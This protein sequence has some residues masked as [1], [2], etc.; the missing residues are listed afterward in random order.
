MKKRFLSLFLV[1]CMVSSLIIAMPVS[2]SAA[3]SGTCGKNLTWTLD[4]NGKLTISG[5]G[6]MDAGYI[7]VGKGLNIRSVVIQNGVTSISNSAFYGNKN[8]TSVKMADSVTSIGASAFGSCENLSSLTLSSNITFIG[9][10]AFQY[11][12]GITSFAIPSKVTVIEKGTF[13][14][15]ENLKTIV[16]PNGVTK[17]GSSA[18]DC[19][20]SLQSITLPNTVREIGAWAF[21]Q[22]KNI[23]SIK[24]PYGVTTIE[25]AT[26]EACTKL[27][28]I[29]IPNTVTTIKHWAINNCYSLKSIT[30]PISVTTLENKIFSYCPNLKDIYYEG[31][32]ND[33]GYIKIDNSNYRTFDF[34]GINIHYE[35]KNIVSDLAQIVY[36]G[37][38]YNL[39]SQ[40]IS[41]DKDSNV[42]V[43]VWVYY[44]NININ[45]EIY[46]CQNAEKFV[47]I[48]NGV[49]KTFV[50]A[51]VFDA[52]KDI[53]IVI[54]N[55]R[56]GEARSERTGLKIVGD[57][58]SGEFMPEGEIEG[59]NYKL[60]DGVSF[61]VPEGIPIFEGTEIK[62]DYDFI[63]I[64]FEYDHEDS[65]KINV[66]LGFD[67]VHTDGEKNKYFKNFDF[68]EYKKSIKKAA[69]K[70]NRTL[71][72]LRH[73]FKLS[74]NC[75]M[76]LFGGK[77]IG[78]GKGKSSTDVDCAGYAEFKMI[79]GR[80]QFIEGQL[81]LNVEASYK[82]QGQLF[83]WT[84]PVYYEIGV[85]IGAGLE[86]DMINI[87]P[88]QF[89]PEF[90][91]YLTAKL[92]GE[93]GGGIGVAKFATV[94]ASGEGSLNMKTALH[95]EYFKAWGEGEANFNVKIFGKEVAKKTFAKG[96]FL[97]YETGNANGL[98]KDN[99]IIVFE[100]E[101]NDIGGGGFGG[102]GGG[103]ILSATAASL[104]S[105]FNSISI[106]DTYENESRAYASSSTEW[107]GDMP[108]VSLFDAEYTSKNLRLLA[109]NVYTESAPIMCSIDGQ[110]I[111][112]M[113]WDN[114]ER[115]AANRT[116]LV[117]SVYDDSEGVWSAPLPVC[118]DGTADFYPNFNDGYLV[119]QN[120]KS[121]L[122]DSMSL[123][124]IA[125]LG[126]I[127][128]S[129]WNGNGFD[130]PVVLTNNDMLDTQ[131]VVCAFES[132]VS[133]IWTTNSE[134]DILGLSGDNSIV[135]S[136][137][138]GSAWSEPEVIKQGLN[139][140]TNLA[141]GY[142]D[143][144][145]NIAYIQDEDGDL[146]TIDD[147]DISIISDSGEYKLTD[148]DVLDS[149][150]QVKGDKIYYYSNGNIEYR[151]LGSE[152]INTFFAD[153]KA[154]LTDNFSVSE[155]S[156]GG[157]VILWAK[158]IDGATEIFS[159]I[160]NDGK[161]SDEIQI[162][163]TGNQSKYPTAVL[164][165]DGS[166]YIA[167]NNG[168]LTDGE[169][170]QT[171]LY[172][173]DLT[174]S[175]DLSVT[176]AYIDEDTMTVF[177][178]V[179]NS[180]ELNIDSYTVSLIDN[181][182]VNSQ[183]MVTEELK[184]GESA[185]VEIEYIKP[186][187]LTKHT[188]TL[189]VETENDEYNTENNSAELTVGNCDIKITDI[190]NHEILPTSVAVATISNSG[191]SD[192]G[193]VTVKLRKDKA[194]G[195]VV[196]TQTI[197]NISAGTSSE[198]SFNY[199][200]IENDNIQWYIT[201]EAENDEI[202]LGNNDAY[203]INNCLS[204]LP[205]YSQAILRYDIVDEKL[206]VNGYAENNTAVDLSGVS[207]LAVY[208]SKDTLKALTH[209]DAYVYKYDSSSVDLTID[210][211]TYEKGDYIKLFLWTDLK[212]IIPVC[213]ATDSVVIK[214]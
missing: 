96:D 153:A 111:M 106:S 87:D 40:P 80:Y 155:S 191:Y 90:E 123:D 46:L 135:K 179:K 1:I 160:L 37:V 172:V 32:K 158:S 15:C 48:E 211:Y 66:V 204:D 55:I 203:F 134:N 121:L 133:V 39:L 206:I 109:E 140:I 118:D 7:W 212:C 24:I 162:S 84:V 93:I 98:L 63:P 201:A 58:A 104:Y 14:F 190:Q 85:G 16:I 180:G 207:V 18:F 19:C 59:V 137:L 176:D 143:T 185:E 213:E 49:S 125:K 53:Y 202:S 88:E 43:T 12:K 79:D 92:A 214:E 52:D 61:T 31:S 175:Y 91:A 147:R 56:T 17:I 100:D 167:Y 161:W 188:I 199:N 89:V 189:S 152:E 82:Y 103:G 198:V 29:E 126:E 168:I 157:A 23:T 6:E 9:Q 210:D 164:E 13:E 57:V 144:G 50:P 68:A 116:M 129:K 34:Y 117:Y 4:D 145:L 127:C 124:D 113:L 114:S 77:V 45:Q 186:L 35:N 193:A 173:I 25:Q 165:D 2:V 174:P 38:S 194:D 142:A 205:D 47:E 27:S 154:G 81:C 86:G 102:G 192:T 107:Y 42:E 26:F 197:S 94:G 170:T 101:N 30:I 169:I 146:Q 163:E 41:I 97:I 105:T 119:W 149:N 120:E 22:C 128:V 78:G 51:K 83:I 112:V 183:I 171:D 65:N 181:D 150:P 74:N 21:S 187:D 76:N 182:D 141:A 99:D 67:I 5:T 70:Q 148:N 139:T 44:K 11:C 54:R 8:L 72:Q 178:T 136:S 62:W 208:N 156:N 132:E 159:T 33:W 75:K 200:I 195:E 95:K 69:S 20:R 10:E 110:K 60:I 177:A 131:P 28:S 36:N 122:D 115:D 209:S 184:A 108:P 166:I 130:T 3:I 73:D 71:K 64:S 196:D 151:V 138:I